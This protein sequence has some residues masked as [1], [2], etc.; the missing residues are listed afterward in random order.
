MEDPYRLEGEELTAALNARDKTKKCDN[1][2]HDSE[3]IS[4]VCMQCGW[5][6]KTKWE[7]KE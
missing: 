4:T 3:D 2:K 1:C 6:F 7:A 5:T